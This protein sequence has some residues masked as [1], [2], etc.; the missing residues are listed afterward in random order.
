MGVSIC[1]IEEYEDMAGFGGRENKANQS[2]FGSP[3]VIA[4]VE[5][6]G[7]A[8]YN[9]RFVFAVR[10]ARHFEIAKIN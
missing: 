4:G 5:S 9:R 6:P 1:L 8:G 3:A 10:Q 2:Q 7:R